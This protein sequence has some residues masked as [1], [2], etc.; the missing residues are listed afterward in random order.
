LKKFQNIPSKISTNEMTRPQT[1][2]TNKTNLDKQ[3]AFGRSTMY[4]KNSSNKENIG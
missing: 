3:V 2:T 1:A 4:Q